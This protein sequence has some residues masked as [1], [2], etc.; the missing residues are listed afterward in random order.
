MAPE[1]EKNFI[2]HVVEMNVYTY[3]Q[4]AMPQIID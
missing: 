3:T 1:R 4:T 2:L